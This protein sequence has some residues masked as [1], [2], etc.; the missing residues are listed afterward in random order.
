MMSTYGEIGGCPA[1]EFQ[2]VEEAG[3]P[4]FWEMWHIVGGERAAFVTY[5]CDPADRRGEASQREKIVRSFRWL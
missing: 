4:S 3:G 1:A 2:F 5:T